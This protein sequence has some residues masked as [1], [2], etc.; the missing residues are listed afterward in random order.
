MR[1][2]DGLADRQPE[3]ETA[4]LLRDRPVALLKSPEDPRQNVRRDTNARVL[5]FHDEPPPS[6]ALF[7][8]GAHEDLSAHRSEF[9]RVLEHV[10][11]DLRESRRIDPRQ[12]VADLQLL[13]A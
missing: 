1:F 13:M 10:P 12:R 2:H 7:F 6:V 3:P 9:D 5:H 4:E 11:K 8:A